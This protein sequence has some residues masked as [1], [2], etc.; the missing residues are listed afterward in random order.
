[1]EKIRV[2]INSTRMR[3]ALLAYNNKIKDESEGL[4]TAAAFWQ[5]KFKFDFFQSLTTWQV[6]LCYFIFTLRVEK[7]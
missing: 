4:F 6:S 1:M 2:Q 5:N 3:L 7:D